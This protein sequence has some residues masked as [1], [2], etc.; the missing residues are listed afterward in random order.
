MDPGPLSAQEALDAASNRLPETKAMLAAH[1]VAITEGGGEP[2]RTH[3]DE[4]GKL[5]AA[6]NEVADLMRKREALPEES[7]IAIHADRAVEIAYQRQR[8]GNGA[9]LT[10][11]PTSS[12][13]AGDA[14]L[15]NPD[16][17]LL[18]RRMSCTAPRLPDIDR[19]DHSSRG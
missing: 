15:E 3:L 6:E 18:R 9:A 14:V 12:T 4:H 13:I 11:T 2:A 10:S 17:T 5:V 8:A 16:T 19:V 1:R 7:V